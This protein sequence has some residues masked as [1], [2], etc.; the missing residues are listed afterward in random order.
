MNLLRP[1]LVLLAAVGCSIHS[2]AASAEQVKSLQPLRSPVQITKSSYFDG[3]R[4]IELTAFKGKYV[5]VNFWATWCGPCVS[6]M[7]SLDRLAKKLAKE[8]I[9][10]VAISEDE[11]GV[12]QVRPFVKK[13]QLNKLTILYDTSKTAFRDFGLRGLPTTYLINPDG[14]VVSTLEGSAV[15]DSGPVY[16]QIINELRASKK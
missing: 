2:V 14:K 15:W 1:I 12:S 8:N 5:L 4:P 7:P 9:V 16:N 10:V 11:G 13:L 3:Q 6:E